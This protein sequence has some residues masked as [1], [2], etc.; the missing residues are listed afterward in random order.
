MR[1]PTISL[2]SALAMAL[3]LG[4]CGSSSSS[5]THTS[6]AA[7]SSQST[8][9]ATTG[10]VVKTAQNA[11]V[12][13]VILVDAQGR[14]LYHLTGEQGGKFICT[15]SSCVAIWHPLTVSAGAAP[16]GVASLATVK[17]PDG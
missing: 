5:S 16:T 9:T 3:A 7:A 8:T 2:A 1:R 4:A 6:T 15:A 12:G 14:T 10:V 13:H 17:R 11:T